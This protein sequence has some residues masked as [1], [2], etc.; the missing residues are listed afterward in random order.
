MSNL[1]RQETKENFINTAKESFLVL[2][3]EV[4]G[5]AMMTTLV[6]NYYNQ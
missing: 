3:Y 4:I 5:T 1:I 2:L 6:G